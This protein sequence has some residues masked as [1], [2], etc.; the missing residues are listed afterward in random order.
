MYVF[1]PL[2]TLTLTLLLLFEMK[3]TFF[4]QLFFTVSDVMSIGILQLHAMAIDLTS[5]MSCLRFSEVTITQH[6]I[7]LE[8][9]KKHVTRQ[10]HYLAARQVAR[11]VSLASLSL[12]VP[13]ILTGYNKCFYRATVL[14]NHNLHP[15]HL[16]DIL[17]NLMIM[18]VWESLFVCILWKCLRVL[19]GLD[20][21]QSVRELLG[22]PHSLHLFV[23]LVAHFI[24]DVYFGLHS[25]SVVSANNAQSNNT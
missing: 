3:C 17:L 13:F 21:V 10:G 6:K 11:V 18:A 2:Y 5:A 9:D 8:I 25:F 24:S 7:I 14:A 4:R 20:L 12:F 16:H 23:P 22:A 15:S 19:L 1:F